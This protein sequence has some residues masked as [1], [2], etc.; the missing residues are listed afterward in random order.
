L[1]IDQNTGKLLPCDKLEPHQL[2]AAWTGK[3]L[4][5]R[6]PDTAKG[7]TEPKIL[8][9]DEWVT[10]RAYNKLNEIE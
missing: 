7:V 5:I 4:V 2:D 9:D 3:I 1:T 6:M 10:C 8:Q